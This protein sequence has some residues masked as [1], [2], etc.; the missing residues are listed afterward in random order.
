MN[1][2]RERQLTAYNDDI[3]SST[4]MRYEEDDEGE[5]KDLEFTDKHSMNNT[6]TNSK[7]EGRETSKKRKHHKNRKLKPYQTMVTN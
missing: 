2:I 5:S 3:S 6:T 7:K 4:F 1:D